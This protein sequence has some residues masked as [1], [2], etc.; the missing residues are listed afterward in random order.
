MSI[1]EL[2]L[3]NTSA[4][5]SVDIHGDEVFV[6]TSDNVLVSISKQLVENSSE[7]MSKHIKLYSSK[8]LIPYNEYN[9]DL[10][11]ENNTVIRVDFKESEL[12][13]TVVETPED[14]MNLIRFNSKY[15]IVTDYSL[16]HKWIARIKRDVRENIRE[17]GYVLSKEHTSKNKS[18][19]IRKRFMCDLFEDEKEKQVEEAKERNDGEYIPRYRQIG[20]HYVFNHDDADRPLDECFQLNIH[21]RSINYTIS[22][23]GPN[24]QEFITKNMEKIEEFVKQNK[25]QPLGKDMFLTFP[26]NVYMS[27]LGQFKD[28]KPNKFS[29]AQFQDMPELMEKT[30]KDS[31]DTN[32]LNKDEYGRLKGAFRRENA[33]I[34]DNPAA[35]SSSDG[36]ASSSSA[37][38]SSNAASSTNTPKPRTYNYES[39]KKQYHQLDRKSYQNKEFMTFLTQEA[40]TSKITVALRT[41]INNIIKLFCLSYNTYNLVLNNEYGY[42]LIVS[43]MLNLETNYS[44]AFIKSALIYGFNEELTSRFK[45]KLSPRILLDNKVINGTF[46][47]KNDLLTHPC[48]KNYSQNPFAVTTFKEAKDSYE[49]ELMRPYYFT[50][51]RGIYNYSEFKQNLAI[52]SENL[53]DNVFDD[54][55]HEGK[56]IAV[57]CGSVMPACTII[58]P[59]EA[60]WKDTPDKLYSKKNSASVAASSSSSSN[61][62]PVF[63]NTEHLKMSGKQLYYEFCYPSRKSSNQ[64][65]GTE[66]PINDLLSMS[67]EEQRAKF[68]EF[69]ANEAII[70]QQG[71]E[72][73]DIDIA[74]DVLQM[75]KAQNMEIYETIVKNFPE[76][77]D[78]DG[79]SVLYLNGVIDTAN[80]FTDEI[81]K[82]EFFAK[83]EEMIRDKIMSYINIIITNAKVNNTPVYCLPYVEKIE[84]KAFYRYKLR[85]FAKDIELFP[86]F[87]APLTIM[88][89]HFSCVRA[90]YTGADVKMFPS[91]VSTAY[92]SFINFPYAVYSA[93]RNVVDIIMKY[94]QRGFSFN[95]DKRENYLVNKYINLSAAS[96]K[97]KYDANGSGAYWDRTQKGNRCIYLNQNYKSDYWKVM[98]DNGIHYGLNLNR[99]IFKRKNEL[100]CIYVYN[101]D[102]KPLYCKDL[103]DRV[104]IL[105]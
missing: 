26:D 48:A 102:P 103:L 76:E 30:A 87:N 53:L 96:D 67:A 95:L 17:F 65:I 60:A 37:S 71:G 90:Y 46:E 64:F 27:R 31:D 80:H 73:G 15:G 55:F 52:Y 97:P 7:L 78:E 20:I 58:N 104:N 75:F 54:N 18:T 40:L 2:N 39:V 8:Y 38:D 56:P 89:F 24:L 5:A 47:Y 51:K 88:D 13:K 10:K 49:N 21:N 105:N 22:E 16:K 25:E 69:I 83:Y 29:F 93:R 62:S 66:I 35:A 99:D 101:M 36:A 85:G 19:L 68:D 81:K 57:L 63:K 86:V 41:Q 43:A 34:I 82:T 98:C 61:E 79:S 42:K 28:P 44:V 12:P 32:T 1:I 92:T 3:F 59:M 33:Q 45:N 72:F 77:T 74:V 4:A 6:L 50:G 11:D 91:F 100:K 70:E 9:Y 23:V 14:F 84:G 94:Y